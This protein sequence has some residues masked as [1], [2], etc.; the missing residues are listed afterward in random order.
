MT[1]SISIT[2]DIT[3]EWRREQRKLAKNQH[4]FFFLIIAYF[5][6]FTG[7]FACVIFAIITFGGAIIIRNPDMFSGYGPT[8]SLFLGAAISCLWLRNFVNRTEPNEDR[9]YP[10]GSEVSYE[11][12]S[13][14]FEMSCA[15]RRWYTE[16]HVV[17]KIDAI[18][19]TLILETAFA[20]M[21]SQLFALP[22]PETQAVNQLKSW[23][24][25]ASGDS[26]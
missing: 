5:A 15:G 20:T 25:A 8:V 11:F 10:L 22:L 9:I 4:K 26:Q 14:G 6:M 24:Q 16:W 21:P 3:K 19:K 1:E 13:K 17:D 7:V 12:D 2:Y 23:H 18:K